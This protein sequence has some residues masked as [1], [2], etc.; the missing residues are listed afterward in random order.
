MIRIAVVEDE[1]KMAK[2]LLEYMER[3]SQKTGNIYVADTFS[4][5]DSFLQQPEGKY[6][7]VLFDIILPG[8]NGIE[9]AKKLR[10]RDKDIGIVFI[11]NMAQYA[12]KGY[13]VHAIDYILKPVRYPD[14]ENKFL[15]AVK[16]VTAQ[17]NEM[18]ILETTEGM[19]RCPV[20]ELFCVQ[21]EGH[22]VTYITEHGE[23][24]KRGFSLKNAQK[25]LSRYSFIRISGNYLVNPRCIRNIGEEQI[26]VG[27]KDIPISKARRAE[28]LNALAAYFGSQED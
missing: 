10:E 20:S 6:Q 16:Q 5:G 23:Y 17:M 25:Q 1:A 12:V 7:L 14:F 21:G 18:I 3:V 24:V 11:T 2:T 26:V 9:A 15:R 13:E 27:N 22:L 4:S 28:L 19:L 8:I